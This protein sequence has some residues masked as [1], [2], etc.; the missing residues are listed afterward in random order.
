MRKQIYSFIMTVLGLTAFIANPASAQNIN[1]NCNS[2]E[3]YIMPDGSYM[4]ISLTTTAENTGPPVEVGLAQYQNTPCQTW[5]NTNQWTLQQGQYSWTYNY[6]PND[7]KACPAEPSGGIQAAVTVVAYGWPYA[8]Y[9]TCLIQFNC[10]V[11]PE[12][13]NLECSDLQAIESGED[14]AFGKGSCAAE[15]TAPHTLSVTYSYIYNY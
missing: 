4:C 14:L 15:F 12:N 5:G 1:P 8:P 9:P 13:T 7:M 2:G 11:T 6:N 3:P 10:R